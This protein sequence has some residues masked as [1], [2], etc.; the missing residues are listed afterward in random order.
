MFRIKLNANGKHELDQVSAFV[1]DSLCN[2]IG[3]FYF[4]FARFYARTQRISYDV[5]RKSEGQEWES[6]KIAIT[7]AF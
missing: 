1:N 2:A 4:R 6:K 3:G 7:W 5:K